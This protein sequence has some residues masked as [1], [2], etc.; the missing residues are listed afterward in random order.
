MADAN[1]PIVADV[2]ARIEDDDPGVRRQV[3]ASLGELPEAARIPAV[4]AL[5]ERDATDPMAT[6]AALSGLR[7]VEAA[8]LERVMTSMDGTPAREAA[9]TML[10]ATVVRSADDVAIQELFGRAGE[11]TRPAWQRAAVLSGFEVAWLNAAAPGTPA[12]RRAPTQVEPPPCPTCPGG[13]AGPGGA[14]AFM[15]PQ[16]GGGRGGPAPIRVSREPG[17][18]TTLAAGGG[19]LADRATRILGR[20]EWPGKPGATL[21]TPLTPDEFRRF[22]EGRT[23]F[24]DLCLACHQADGRGRDRVAPTLVGSDLALAPPHVVAR[25][26]LNGKEGPVGLMPPLGQALSDD[27]VAAALTYIRRQWGNVGSA[28]QPGT[29]RDVRAETADRARPWSHDEIVALAASAGR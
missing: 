16:Q 10:T 25:I 8:V 17:A 26:V 27:Q 3:A 28:V 20:I 24:T 7:G 21:V 13:R 29:V 14:S 12:P 11:T 18:L 15:T 22:E 4:A 19:P 6:D 5:L 2:L 1:H 23:V 9:I